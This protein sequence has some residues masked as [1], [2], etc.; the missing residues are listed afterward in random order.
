M[1]VPGK[2]VSTVL[3][4]VALFIN[5][6]GKFKASIFLLIDLREIFLRFWVGGAKKKLK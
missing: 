6:S 2:T 1:A 4:G 5:E 3:D